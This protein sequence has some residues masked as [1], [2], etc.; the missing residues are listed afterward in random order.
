M[1]CPPHSHYEVCADTC[2]LGCSTV[3]TPI[4]CPDRCSEGCECDSEYLQS[5][6]GCVPMERCGC[7]YSGVCYEVGARPSPQNLELPPEPSPPLI[8]TMGLSHLLTNSRPPSDPFP[9][10]D[11]VHHVLIQ[12]LIF[13]LMALE[14]FF[15]NVTTGNDVL[16]SPWLPK[17][18]L[19][20]FV[21]CLGQDGCPVVSQLG[22]ALLLR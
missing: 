12:S 22:R 20:H 11:R 7:H 17:I 5:F 6:T 3:T 10:P 15:P 4:A 13:P 8:S 18:R 19:N 1:E 9:H 2:S 16:N 14:K 21:L